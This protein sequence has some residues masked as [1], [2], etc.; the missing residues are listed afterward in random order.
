MMNLDP[1]P[2]A[3]DKDITQKGYDLACEQASAMFAYAWSYAME[4]KG[5]PIALR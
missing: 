3:A 5:Q 1:A 4:A 2:E